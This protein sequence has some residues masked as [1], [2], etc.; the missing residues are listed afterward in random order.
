[1]TNFDGTVDNRWRPDLASSQRR[2]REEEQEQALEDMEEI[3]V[4][5]RELSFVPAR[6]KEFRPHDD[7]TA[8]LIRRSIELERLPH[9]QAVK[10]LIEKWT[11]IDRMQAAEQKQRFLEPLIERVR[12]APRDN[13][14]LLVFLMLVFEPVRRSVGREFERVQ[15]GLFPQARDVSWSNRAEAR[16]IRDIDREQM[17]DV[18]REGAIEAVF[19]YPSPPPQYFFPWLREVIA[20]RALDKLKGELSQIGFDSIGLVEGERVQRAI[21]GFEHAEG[22]PS[23]DRRGMREWRAQVDMRDVFGVVAEFFHNDA[24]AQA[25]RAAVGRLPRAEREVI[26]G[27][28]FDETPVADLASRRRV[29]PSTVYNQKNKA[30]KK[31]RADDPFFT[32]LRAL[33]QVRDAARA[34]Q[35]RAAHPDGR[36][37]DGRRIVLI[38]DKAA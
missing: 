17:R 6:R 16:M 4:H 1:M 31:L 34:E 20:H 15:S 28:Y 37:P 23:R 24:V 19:R 36:L 7:Q 27:H 26:E 25:V 11:W 35:I 10:E 14:H 8:A 38:D 21:A 29:S 13:E 30:E 18:T 22:P 5:S 2:V 33:G 3:V 9:G 12:R 32:A